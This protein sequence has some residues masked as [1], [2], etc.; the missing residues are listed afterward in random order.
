[1]KN[2]KDTA[3]NFCFGV[4]IVLFLLTIALA[5]FGSVGCVG[6]GLLFIGWIIFI[7]F[8]D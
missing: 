5:F 4:M 2:E 7:T 3:N 1:M 8:N 6:T